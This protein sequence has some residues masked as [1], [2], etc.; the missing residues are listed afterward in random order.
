VINARVPKKKAVH[1]IVDKY[2]AHKH[3]KVLERI[4]NHP[5]FIFHFTPTSASWLNAI[6]GLFAKLTKRRLKRSAFRS[7]KDLKEAI[8]RFLDDYQCKP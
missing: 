4:E 8:H 5:R 1:V 2:A 6:E 3:P 7:L